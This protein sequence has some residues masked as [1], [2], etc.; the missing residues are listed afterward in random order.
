MIGHSPWKKKKP[1]EIQSFFALKSQT[2]DF[3]LSILYLNTLKDFK[4]YL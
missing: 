2:K 1:L 3:S 4:Y